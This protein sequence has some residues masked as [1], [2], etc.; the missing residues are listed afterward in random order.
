M[1]ALLLR[2]FDIDATRGFLPNQDPLT[3]LPEPFFVLDALAENL[4]ALLMGGT[5]RIHIEK[6]PEVDINLLQTDGERELAMLLL[7]TFASAYVWGEEVPAL[8]LPR[9]VAVPLW[10][11]AAR[12]GRQPII[13]YA[14]NAL[15][16]WRRIDPIGAI[17]L[18][19]LALVQGFLSGSDE[20]WF[21]LVSV[22]V[23]MKGASG[24][25]NLISAQTAVS[26]RNSDSLLIELEQISECIRRMSTELMRMYE[27]CDPHI[28]FTR[29]RPFVA[30][31]PEPGVIYKGISEIPQKFKGGS[32]GQ[33]SLIQSFDAAL[34]VRHSSEASN[35]F[36]IEMRKYMPPGHRAF[37][38]ALERGPDV[39]GYV[40]ECKIDCPKLVSSYNMCVDL[41]ADF[42]RMHME[43]AIR[44]ITMQGGSNKLDIGTGGTS[45]SAF[46][47][48]TRRE[49]RDHRV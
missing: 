24:L 32:A 35:P 29:V 15:N 28:F 4:P 11:L 40:A 3:R 43:M 44:Y 22:S 1:P 23:E 25:S 33:S 36:L 6:L 49:T 7:C 39:H 8:V 17:E 37:I 47:G 45:L 27:R 16:N 21:Y 9:S 42:R 14:S 13:H 30:S 18:G 31:W 5:S 20:A 26:Q 34:G 48:A 2:D 46:L 12:L 38:S 10:H 19:N 41:L